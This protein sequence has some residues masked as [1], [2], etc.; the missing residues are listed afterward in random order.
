MAEPITL[1]ALGGLGVLGFCGW[2]IKKKFN[3]VDDI[4]T[5]LTKVETKLDVLGDIKDS[6]YHV[7]S[8]VEVIKSKVEYLQDDTGK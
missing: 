1:T 3:Q 6:L 4:D 8:D 2:F 7:R 5:R